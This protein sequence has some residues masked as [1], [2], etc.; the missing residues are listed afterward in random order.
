MVDSLASRR[1]G[2]TDSFHAAFDAVDE[3]ERD[4][5]PGFPAVAVG[6]SP[7]EQQAAEPLALLITGGSGR[8]RTHS[9]TRARLDS[10]VH[11]RTT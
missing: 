10:H 6:G 7:R 9:W 5:I 8:A 2:W 4:L 11:R 1:E 3:V